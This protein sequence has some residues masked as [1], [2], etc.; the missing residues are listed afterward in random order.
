MLE[1]N[2]RVWLA[3][4]EGDEAA[5]AAE[6][7]ALADKAAA[8]EAAKGG[9]TKVFSQEDVNRIMANEKRAYNAEKQ[10]TIDELEALKT[11]ANLTDEERIQYDERIETM[12]NELLT[13]EELTQKE[14]KKLETRYQK[15]V[16]E[17]TKDRE[18]WKQKYV[19]S[20][21]TRAIIDAAISNDAFV[22]EQIVNMLQSNTRLVEELDAEGKPTGDLVPKVK[23][24]DT[25]KD[26]KPVTLELSPIEAVKRMKDMDRFLNLFKGAGTGGIGGMNRSGGTQPTLKNLAKDPAAYRKARKEGKVQ[27]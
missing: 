17:L 24:S 25:D 13:K 6:A 18:G 7:A 14:R 27:L 1:S 20:T 15:E 26:G 4:Y 3:V 9:A 8:A 21:I 19:S 10:K 2:Y 16:D 5:A 22:P 11:K 23:L 12:R